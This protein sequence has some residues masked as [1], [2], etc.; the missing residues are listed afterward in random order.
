MG[1]ILVVIPAHV[2]LTARQRRVSRQHSLVLPD[3]QPACCGVCCWLTL[4][5]CLQA[6]KAQQLRD[7]KVAMAKTLA[8]NDANIKAKKQ[9]AKQQ[10]MALML[11]HS[12]TAAE[13]HDNQS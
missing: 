3:S 13:G 8:E 1:S 12:C 7:D 4:T 2:A 5:S 9:A 10:V 11:H 6:Q